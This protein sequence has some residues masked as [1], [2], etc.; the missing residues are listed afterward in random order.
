MLTVVTAKFSLKR[1]FKEMLTGS[2]SH[3]SRRYRPLSKSHASSFH[4][5]RFNTSP[6][7]YLRAWHRL[8]V[9]G[10]QEQEQTFE[11]SRKIGYLGTG[12]WRESREY[13][14]PV[15]V[16]SIKMKCIYNYCIQRCDIYVPIP[17]ICNQWI[18]TDISLSIDCYWKSM[19][20]DKHTNLHHRLS[21]SMDIN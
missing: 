5:V 9:D 15:N 3:F 21:V 4:S 20:I 12:H 11:L 8:H 19:P 18:P 6:I 7:C 1:V 10:R 16:Q 2:L 14:F 13:Y 17:S